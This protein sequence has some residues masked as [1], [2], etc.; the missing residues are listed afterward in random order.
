MSED[1]TRNEELYGDC[2]EWHGLVGL[3][4]GN[5]CKG[6]CV[7]KRVDARQ[8]TST[9]P[10]ALR[11]VRISLPSTEKL[12]LTGEWMEMDGDG[13]SCFRAGGS[14]KSEICGAGMKGQEGDGAGD[15]SGSRP[16]LWD[17]RQ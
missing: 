17:E 2:M 11:S 10:C 12:G 13:S 9:V 7:W 14:F 3:C 8:R 6:S 16:H 5:R 4:M 1:D 15:S